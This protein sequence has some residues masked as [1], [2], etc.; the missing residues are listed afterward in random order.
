MKKTFAIVSTLAL[1]TISC[2][3]EDTFEN[4]KVFNSEGNP[5]TL[6]RL[7]PAIAHT[8]NQHETWSGT[9]TVMGYESI[10]SGIPLTL[11][12]GDQI[13]ER[14]WTDDQGSWKVTLNYTPSMDLN[15]ACEVP[16]MSSTVKIM[17]DDFN[18]VIKPEHNQSAMLPPLAYAQQKSGQTTTV[19]RGYNNW[20]DD[21]IYSL[22]SSRGSQL[23]PTMVA[24]DT[25]SD[26]FLTY[27]SNSVPEEFP[28]GVNNPGLL[29]DGSTSLYI[30]DSADVWMTFVN[31]GA[32]F[33]NVVGIFTYTANNIPQSAS[34]IDTIWTVFENY[35][36][37]YSG[38]GL[39]PGDKVY[40]G[41]YPAGTYIGFALIGNGFNGHGENFLSGK[42]AYYSIPEIN[43]ETNTDL[44]QHNILLYD[45]TTSRFVIGFEDLYRSGGASDDDF[46][47]A[48]FY[49]SAN[50]ITAI[51]T[52][53]VTPIVEELNDCD[54]DGVP[55]QADI[56]PCDARYASTSTT[57]GRLMFEDLFPYKGDYDFNDI[58][59]DYSAVAWKASSGITNKMEYQFTLK[60]DGG[61]L[62]NGFG[63]SI[64]GLDG[65]AVSNV[66]FGGSEG[67]LETDEEAVFILTTD[68][69]FPSFGFINN[70]LNGNRTSSYPTY[71]VSF[72]ING[73]GQNDIFWGEKL[74]PMIF[75]SADNGKRNEIHLK[76]K[77]PTTEVDVIKIGTGDDITLL[78]DVLF[79]GDWNSARPAERFWA[80]ILHTGTSTT[81]PATENTY[82]DSDGYP[83]AMH[84]DINVKHP[85]EK[86]DIN[87]AYPA[88]STWVESNGDLQTNWFLSE[89]TGKVF[90]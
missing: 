36:R 45:E 85:Y 24:P 58:V 35:S 41:S 7:D 82:T 61:T 43:P 55:D 65:S 28:V 51:D 78:E 76:F 32:G 60:A 80:Q 54:F 81:L 63:F 16:T 5:F 17:S 79:E 87:D 10:L 20:Y 44:L 67:T 15:V 89:I 4:N 52:T 8:F 38:G 69:S 29:A 33:R 39:A 23:L 59:I 53:D 90:E 1:L 31:E 42:K 6:D 13:V 46:N 66:Q 74:N 57:Q 68:C 75:Q 77:R 14:G 22:Q 70:T 48:L 21:R 73:A 56:A 12:N 49:C 25:L 47:D 30:K 18:I 84:L 3:K 9:I 71:S 72:E 86:V 19:F 83:W 26:Q 34:D 37:L 50:P 62:T 88:F 2:Q 40:I 64:D 11:Y 27:I